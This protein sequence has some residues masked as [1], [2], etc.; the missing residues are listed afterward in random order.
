MNY[1]ISLKEN[2]WN[3]EWWKNFYQYFLFYFSD[4]FTLDL[5]ICFVEENFKINEISEDYM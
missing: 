5:K 4:K 2:N 3:I 1:Q